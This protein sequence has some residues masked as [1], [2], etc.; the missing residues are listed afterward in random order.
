[1][2]ELSGERRRAETSLRRDIA[3]AAVAADTADT[4][5]D[6]LLRQL[7][8]VR[9]RRD[10]DR[11][12][13]TQIDEAMERS[14][15]LDEELTRLREED[16]QAAIDAAGF[17]YATDVGEISFTTGEDER[18]QIMAYGLLAVFALGLAALYL[19]LRRS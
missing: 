15:T 10:E 19:V 6:E 14:A 5:E 18:P 4:N 13:Q 12:L 8:D 7:R 2:A 9:D 11:R 16:E 17:I 1:E 3:R